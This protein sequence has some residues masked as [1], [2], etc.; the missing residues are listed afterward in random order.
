[1]K[2]MFKIGCMVMVLGL[3]SFPAWSS[4]NASMST[5][6]LLI[7]AG[8]GPGDSTCDGD[9]PADGTGEGPGPGNGGTGE[10]GGNGGNGPGDGTGEGD[11]PGDGT[12]NGPGDC[13]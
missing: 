2:K 9:A 1:M 10:N 12:G 7:L 11:A 5:D 6:N 4:N 8:W 13:A 3:L